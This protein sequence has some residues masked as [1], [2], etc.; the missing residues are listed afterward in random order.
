MNEKINLDINAQLTQIIRRRDEFMKKQRFKKILITIE[1][2]EKIS[3]QTVKIE[4]FSS[5]KNADITLSIQRCNV[6]SK[7]FLYIMTKLSK[8]I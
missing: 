3:A 1:R 8:S 4:E 5:N 7:K 2:F 6:K